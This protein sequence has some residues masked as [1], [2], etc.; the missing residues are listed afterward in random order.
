VVNGPIVD[1]TNNQRLPA[2]V[3]MVFFMLAF[4]LAW[5]CNDNEGIAIIRREE[6]EAEQTQV[7]GEER[8]L[9]TAQ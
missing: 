8:G 2:V 4:F 7:G 9:T 5:L 3:S 1:K 6:V